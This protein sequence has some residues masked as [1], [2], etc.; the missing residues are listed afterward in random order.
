MFEGTNNKQCGRVALFL[1]WGPVNSVILSF[2]VSNKKNAKLILV[3]YKRHARLLQ[4]F[5]SFNTVWLIAPLS[6]VFYS[7]YVVT[8]IPLLVITT[9]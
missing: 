6:K 7:Y 2:I 9:S 1:V 8:N 5:F 3:F 4:R